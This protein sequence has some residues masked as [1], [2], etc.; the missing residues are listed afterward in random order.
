MAGN[1][2]PLHAAFGTRTGRV[3]TFDEHVGTGTV[4]SDGTDERWFFH[5]TRIADGTRTIPVGLWVSF[6]VEPGP[7]GLEAV[8]LRRRT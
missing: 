4:T 1:V 6:E 5:C 7:T 2:S 3:A 8:Q